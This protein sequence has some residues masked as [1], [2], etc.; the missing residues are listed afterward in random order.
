MAAKTKTPAKN[1]KKAAV[2]LKSPKTP[3]ADKV[4]VKA[5]Q[6]E[7]QAQRINPTVEL[8]DQYL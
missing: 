8:P 4:A 5:K 7:T 2:E 6:I 3:K 1:A